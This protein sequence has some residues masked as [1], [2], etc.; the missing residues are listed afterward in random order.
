MNRRRALMAAARG[1][2]NVIKAEGDFTLLSEGAAPILEHNL[3]TQKIAVLIYPAGK[4][5]AAAGYQNYY[6]LFINAN[7]IFNGDTW[8]LDASSYNTNFSDESSISFPNTDLREGVI[9]QSPWTTQNSW[10][11]AGNPQS[12]TE[13]PSG[14]SNVDYTDNTV[15]IKGTSSSKI[16]AAGKYH[17]I[18]WKLG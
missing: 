12:L 18:V 14:N 2:E 7:A 17:W 9:H 11:A 1:G 8:T 3:G 15:H 5:T 6:A 13:G 10:F 4:I 16:F